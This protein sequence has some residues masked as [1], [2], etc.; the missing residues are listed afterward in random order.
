MINDDRKYVRDAVQYAID[1]KVY[2]VNGPYELR[3]SGEAVVF[4]KQFMI[5]IFL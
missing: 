1:N 5:M 2:V 4:R 3:Q